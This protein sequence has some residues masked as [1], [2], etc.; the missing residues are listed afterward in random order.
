MVDTDGSELVHGQF[1][2]IVN[3]AQRKHITIRQ[4]NENIS[5]DRHMEGMCWGCDTKTFVMPTLTDACFKC[6][7]KRG[8]E[9]IIAIVSKKS[10]GYCFFCAKYTYHVAQLNVQLCIKC[11]RIVR[12]SHSAFRK[13]GGMFNVDPF[14]KYQK[15]KLGKDWKELF[16]NPE[17]WA[18]KI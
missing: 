16:F 15:Q 4:A 8:V 14:W 7:Y 6:S 10:W 12:K 5:Q 1:Q 9:K 3:D 13:G 17:H 2:G 11:T 18:K